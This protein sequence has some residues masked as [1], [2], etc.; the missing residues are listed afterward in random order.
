MVWILVALEFRFRF[1][2]YCR[3]YLLMGGRYVS[4]LSGHLLD[5]RRILGMR[6]ART[7]WTH[8]SRARITR[9]PPQN[10]SLRGFSSG[11][12]SILAA[13]CVSFLPPFRISVCGFA[14][15]FHMVICVVF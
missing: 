11:F 14:W 10:C 1:A 15:L 3:F 6:S 7:Y 2:V 9:V 4:V 13:F 8:M 12:D 5:L